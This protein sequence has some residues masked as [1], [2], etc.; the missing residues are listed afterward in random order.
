MNA[1]APP[2]GMTRFLEASA[3][4]MLDACTSCGAC[5]EICPIIPQAGLTDTPAEEV[6]RGILTTLRTGDAIE[7]PAQAWAAQCDG[8]DRCVPA[9]PEA[10][11]PRSML[12]IAN[13]LSARTRPATPELFRKMSRAIKMM[14]AMQM[15]PDD[16]A[17]LMRHKASRDAPVVFYVGCNAVRTPHLLFN[18]MYVLDALQ[19]DYEVSGGPASCCGIIHTKW[20]GK[21]DTAERVTDNSIDSFEDYKPEKVLSWCPS[22][23]MH[24]GEDLSE[25][26]ETTYEF[27]HV[28]RYMLQRGTELQA[29]MTTPVNMNVLVHAHEGMSDLGHNVVALL[30]RV[31]GLNIVDVGWEAGYTCSGANPDLPPGRKAD[32]RAATMERARQPDIDALVTLYHGCHGQLTAACMREGIPTVNFTDLLVRALGGEPRQDALA[33]VRALGDFRAMAEAVMPNL[34][35]N[36]IDVDPDWLADLMPEL[37][38]SA[39]FKGG[40]KAFGSAKD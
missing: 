28:T 18:T 36:R 24:L 25:F 11:N 26:R 1:P 3:A 33:A 22:C 9:C 6:M 12:L 14:A 2:D 40:L 39:E 20:E 13:S 8:C 31:P 30:N 34:K 37:L 4:E 15:P 29:L 10:I 17:K 7:G 32:T 16:V 38:T 23:Q 19:V 21:L 27:D 5:V 35:A